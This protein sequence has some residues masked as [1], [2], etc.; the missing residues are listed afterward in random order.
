MTTRGFFDTPS[1]AWSKNGRH[2][3]RPPS[4]S[5]VDAGFRACGG[6]GQTRQIQALL[7]RLEPSPFAAGSVSGHAPYRHGAPLPVNASPPAPASA[8]TA[9]ETPA[10]AP[11]A[12]A[13]R[14]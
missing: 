4:G 10:G 1:M 13:D 3:C 11:A 14:D 7:A 2:P 9:S 8:D 12:S 5:T 6:Q